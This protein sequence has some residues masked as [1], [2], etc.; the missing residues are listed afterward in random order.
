[1]AQQAPE[2][3]VEEAPRPVYGDLYGRVNFQQDGLNTQAH[4]AGERKVMILKIL[5]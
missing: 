5:G 4:V 1:M 2:T 3:S